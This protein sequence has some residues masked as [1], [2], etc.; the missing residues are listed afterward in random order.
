MLKT[1]RSEVTEQP[2]LACSTLTR[3]TMILNLSQDSS[4]RSNPGEAPAAAVAASV[5]EN[6]AKWTSK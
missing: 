6:V 2:K 5:S 1:S 4:H 3:L